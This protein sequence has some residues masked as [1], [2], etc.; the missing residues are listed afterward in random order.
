VTD[1]GWN[2]SGAY[3]SFSWQVSSQPYATTINAPEMVPLH[4]IQL[5]VSW[6]D[7]LG[8]KQFEVKTLLPQRRPL[9]G[10]VVR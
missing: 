5:I 2:E 8:Q 7:G 1:Q 10:E 9:P 4:Q 3:A 6:T